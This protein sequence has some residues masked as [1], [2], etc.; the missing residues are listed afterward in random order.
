[1]ASAVS[2]VLLLA[3][4][5]SVFS[6]DVVPH[7]NT[8][9]YLGRWYQ[10]YANV[11]VYDSFER[12]AVCATAD[13]GIYGANNVSVFNAERVK[14]PTGA[15][16]VIHGYAFRPD[17]SVD[18]KLLVHFF[19]HVNGEYWIVDI[20]PQTFYGDRDCAPCYEYSV[21]TDSH[22]LSLFVLARDP[23][24]FKTNYQAKILTDLKNLG[25]TKFY[26]A[27]KETLQNS[28]CEYPPKPSFKR[29]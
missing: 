6:I 8:T 29:N 15:E 18:A 11:L 4:V 27:P 28:E 19:G 22:Q 14:V 13:Y 26:N 10:M 1:M 12:N 20:G 23:V 2:A 3:L 24:A 21:V 9:A 25:F 7:V 17:T 16:S 5:G